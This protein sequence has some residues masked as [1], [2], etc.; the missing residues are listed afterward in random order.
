[1]D[2]T[3]TTTPKRSNH[4]HHD[5]GAHRR[6][7]LD[8]YAKMRIGAKDD[9]VVA[10]EI[11]EPI[12]LPVVATPQAADPIIK[13]T[14]IQATPA[15][16]SM[17]REQVQPLV[18][19]PA[20]QAQKQ[21]SEV[22]E[23][24]SYLDTLLHHHQQRVAQAPQA[25]ETVSHPVVTDNTQHLIDSDKQNK[26]EANL[27]ALYNPRPLT[28]QIVKNP[29]SASTMH[30]RTIVASAMACGILSVGIFAFSGR[31]NPQPVVAEP[32]GSPV[33]EVEAP[34][35]KAP[36]GAPVSTHTDY[37]VSANPTDPV[38][39]IAASI[40]V[41]ARINGLG[42]T[43]DGLIAVP[44]S[45]TTVGW[46]NRGSTVGQPGPVVMVGHFTG[47]YGG[48]FDKLK[49]IKD[50]DLI[51]IKNGKNEV[52]TYRVTAKNEYA[53][54]QVPMADIFKKSDTSRLEII[55]CSGKWQSNSYN[56]RIVVSAELVQ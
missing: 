26:I 23:R 35:T 9:I 36:T 32:I 13:Q 14:E 47:G 41:N 19:T 25:I 38:R 1:M 17:I 44:R 16:T 34:E 48:V 30:V 4:F 11:E 45:Y 15:I 56:N 40:G 29:N 50:G 21:V 37:S 42:N 55:T 18:T 10:E 27:N 52:F 54:E 49:D 8:T 46:Y 7:Y 33:I 2:T 6:A 20:P 43:A 28:A 39:I 12:T 3:K 53:K 51:T 24:K 22:I 5:T 31:Y